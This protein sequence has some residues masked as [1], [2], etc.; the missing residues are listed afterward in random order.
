ML[1]GDVG[2][3]SQPEL[4]VPRLKPLDRDS[5]RGQHGLAANASSHPSSVSGVSAP[6]WRGSGAVISVLY[7]RRRSSAEWRIA[8]NVIYAKQLDA[9]NRMED[10]L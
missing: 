5:E 2:P 1:L 9:P 8:A 3:V 10:K 7:I 4:D 6:G